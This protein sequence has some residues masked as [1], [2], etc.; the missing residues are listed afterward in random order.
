MLPIQ[1]NDTRLHQH[2]FSKSLANT[3]YN[4]TGPL[5]PFNLLTFNLK[6]DSFHNSLEWLGFYL[7]MNIQPCL[8]KFFRYAVFKLL[9]N[10]FRETP[11]PL[12]CSDH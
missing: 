12:V 11:S 10:A 6:D 3:S 8:G 4:M 1:T 2:T 9:E 5:K 7:Q